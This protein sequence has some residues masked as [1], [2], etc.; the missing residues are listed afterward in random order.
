MTTPSS[1]LAALQQV[2]AG[3][4]TSNAAQSSKAA[5]DFASFFSDKPR[6]LPEVPLP[7]RTVSPLACQKDLSND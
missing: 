6:P 2:A 1:F 5:A 3:P 7:L 4:T